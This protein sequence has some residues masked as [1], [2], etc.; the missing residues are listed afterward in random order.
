MAV[1]A[2]KLQPNPKRCTAIDGTFW[3]CRVSSRLLKILTTFIE[4]AVF[5]LLDL[6]RY[7]CRL[8]RLK[9]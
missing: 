7:L 5:H 8:K 9:A 2:V 4:I 3:P 6:F 1:A